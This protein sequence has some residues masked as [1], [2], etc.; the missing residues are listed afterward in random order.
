M[1][2][3]NNN[4]N[5]SNQNNLNEVPRSS[6]LSQ[7]SPCLNPETEIEKHSVSPTLISE[8]LARPIMTTI[9][10]IDYFGERQEIE[11]TKEFAEKYKE[12]IRREHLTNRKETRRHTSLNHLEEKGFE[13]A[14]SA[15]SPDDEY[16]RSVLIANVRS[17]ILSL[18]PSQQKLIRQLFYQDLNM[19]EI[20]K[21]ENVTPSAI[22]HRWGRIKE[23]I[24]YKYIISKK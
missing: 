7:A 10:Y 23:K 3:S 18:T 4:Q 19:N 14:S 16:E 1:N 2:T 13:F 24:N 20:A 11:V 21:L 5:I 17:I 9:S 15:A 12:I 22:R 6:N 8:P